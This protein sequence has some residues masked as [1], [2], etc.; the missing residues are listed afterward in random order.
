MRIFPQLKAAMSALILA[1]IATVILSVASPPASADMLAMNRAT[2]ANALP[3]AT[4]TATVTGSAVDLVDYGG[5]VA[6]TLMSGAATAGTLPTLDVKVTECDTS[7]GTYTD[8][9]GATWT[10]VTDAAAADE[11]IVLNSD[12]LKRYIK[13]VGTI[14]GTATP[15][16][17][18]GVHL[19]AFKDNR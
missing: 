9:S 17:A 2:F 15:T 7:G 6:L 18:F 16:F 12:S 3:M 4:R 13:I 1:V 8:V 5:Y 19:T 11:T 10:E 14:G